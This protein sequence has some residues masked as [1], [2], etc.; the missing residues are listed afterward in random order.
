MKINANLLALSALTSASAFTPAH[1]AFTS[2]ALGI[3]SY[4]GSPEFNSALNSEPSNT[5][6]YS[7]VSQGIDSTGGSL[8]SSGGERQGS[9]PRST[10]GSKT[11]TTVQGGSLR[12]WSF[13]DPNVDRVQ[14]SLRTEGRPLNA[15]IELWQG[16]DNT[17]QKLGVYVED[18]S[19]RPFNAV[20]ETPRGSNAVAIYNTASLEYPL[21]AIVEA[22]DAKS[23]E[24]L[25]SLTSKL[26][27]SNGRTIQGG[28]I[29]TYPFSPSVGSVQVLLTT[30]GRPLNAR[31]ELLQGP[32]NNKQ[33]MEIYTE[34]G[35]ERPFF[36]VV[37]T[38]GTGNVVRIVNT[39]TMEYP[40]TARVEPFMVE[41][42]SEEIFSNDNSWWDNTGRS[43]FFFSQN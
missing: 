6:S 26:V 28:A 36:V 22:D 5:G 13:A 37:E 33:V 25:G 10:F 27:E 21:A 40:L 43:N 31:I 41:P 7:A 8:R 17:P 12:T 14:V 20:I 9:G 32:N 18:G 23:S 4:F 2:S 39:A 42:G 3:N 24:S 19:T 34:D 16:P 11:P 30:D 35:L 38:P 29:H 1:K 15:N